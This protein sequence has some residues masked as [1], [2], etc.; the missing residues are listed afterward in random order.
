MSEVKV[1]TLIKEA[2]N[3]AKTAVH[4]DSNYNYSGACDYYDKS[5]LTIDDIIKELPTNSDEWLYFINQR[6]KYDERLELLR[7]YLISQVS[8]GSILT[9]T[10]I[11]NNE[12]NKKKNIDFIETDIENYKLENIP[13]ENAE[14]PYWLLR[15]IKQTMTT[16]GFITKDIFVIKDIWQQNDL[17]FSGINTKITAFEII[18]KLITTN[19]DTLYISDDEDSLSLAEIAFMNIY[20]ELYHLQNHLSKPFPY[21]KELKNIRIN[22]P[23][24][25]I[26]EDENQVSAVS[27]NSSTN[28]NTTTSTTNNNTTSTTFTTTNTASN[29]SSTNN[30]TKTLSQYVFNWSK[31]VRKY[32]EV[33]YQR[34]AVALPTKLTLEELEQYKT[35]VIKLCDKCQV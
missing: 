14:I 3:L 27:N 23:S 13:E 15:N 28:I 31:N 35:L 22:I 9:P 19:I 8:T 7:Y 30:N 4:F 29:N 32:A 17:K 18:I 2:L 34:L 21:I 5:I 20:N 25:Q 24:S 26:I 33:S 11:S 6:T 12:I 10:V 16:G 1:I